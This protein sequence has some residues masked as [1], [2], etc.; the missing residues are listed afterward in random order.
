MISY[1]IMSDAAYTYY[2]TLRQGA[3][4]N[5]RGVSDARKQQRRW[6][7]RCIGR[8]MSVLNSVSYMCTH[9]DYVQVFVNMVL[10]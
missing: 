5:R 4:M 2:K 6:R 10:L 3:S 8:V 7:E 1:N 9:Y